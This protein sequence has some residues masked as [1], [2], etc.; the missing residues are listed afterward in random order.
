[1]GNY[2]TNTF[3]ILFGSQTSE[4]APGSQTS[5]TASGSQTSETA[6]GS[7]QEALCN[8]AKLS[9]KDPEC[10]DPLSEG[11]SYCGIRGTGFSDMLL[12]NGN[13]KEQFINIVKKTHKYYDGNMIEVAHNFL[14]KVQ[15]R[16]S[17]DG[18]TASPQSFAFCVPICLKDK[19]VNLNLIPWRLTSE[20]MM[21]NGQT[22]L[23]GHNDPNYRDTLTQD[24]YDELLTNVGGDERIADLHAVGGSFFLLACGFPQ[25]KRVRGGEN[26]Y[27]LGP[28]VL[29][30]FGIFGKKEP[31]E[32]GNNLT[33]EEALRA[34]KLGRDTAANM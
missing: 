16:L 33:K 11:G 14:R 8:I 5:E 18:G 3:A 7:R 10:F 19:D 9:M 4:T 12:P 27:Y 1:M 31:D 28:E 29:E 17:K 6:S 2:L 34:E 20:L 30:Q 23:V 24:G 22:V 25:A 21:P 32:A 26:K 13:T 15:P